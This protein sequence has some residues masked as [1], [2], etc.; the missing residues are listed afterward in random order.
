MVNN[1]QR[2]IRRVSMFTYVYH[3]MPC[4][5]LGFFIVPLVYVLISHLTILSLFT[6]AQVK[7]LL[8]LIIVVDIFA[9][10]SGFVAFALGLST[11]GIRL[12]GNELK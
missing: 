6:N 10:L 11:K 9:A 12:L 7:E 4:A 8:W 1:E 2:P 5:L 3:E